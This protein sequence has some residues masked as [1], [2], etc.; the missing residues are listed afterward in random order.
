L[1]FAVGVLPEL[2]RMIDFGS[3]E[4]FDPNGPGLGNL[5]GQISP[6]T[7]LGIWPSGDFRVAPGDGAAPAV[8]FFLGA[9]FATALLVA[10]IVRGIRA[11]EHTLFA[12]VATVLG[13]YLATRIGGTPYT[14]AKALEAAAPVLTLAIFL[15][16]APVGRVSAPIGNKCAPGGGVVGVALAAYALAAAACSVLALASAPVGP[17]SYSPALTGLRP[18]LGD[19]PTLVLAPA[20]LLGER[21][22]ARYIAWELRGGRV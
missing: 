14:A 5:F 8:V 21:H 4:T 16:L 18:L 7:A 10:G 15:P 13:V 12:G 22:G 3:F 20:E 1:V 19:A 11:R 17:A 2:G 9:A 6:F